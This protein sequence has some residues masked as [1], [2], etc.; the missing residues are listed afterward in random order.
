MRALPD[1]QR[2]FRRALLGED[3]EDAAA[4]VLD[5]GLT[6]RGRLALYRHHVLSMLTGVL[7]ATFPV[8]CRLV[9]ARF[10]RW[11]ADR[12]IREH[13]P[14]GPCLFEYG[15]HLPEFLAKFPACQHL[16][17]LPDVARL[18]WALNAALHAEDAVPHDPSTLRAMPPEMVARLTFRLDPSLTLLRSPWPIARIWQANQPGSA[19][20]AVVDLDEGG[21]CLEV[22]RR[23]DDVIVRELTPAAH[24]L[25][26]GLA[27]GRNLEDAAMEALAQDTG[28]DLTAALAELLADGVVVGWDSHDSL[29][30]ARPR[31]EIG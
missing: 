28:F 27:S 29:G 12:F 3:D 23:G 5:D 17:Y 14:E 21:A 18:E 8:V 1:V 13:P 24:A 10:F 6:A 2:D 4:A 31:E 26:A 25:R 19:R 20:E 22:R 30:D 11:V 16:A 7:E 15:A 9:D